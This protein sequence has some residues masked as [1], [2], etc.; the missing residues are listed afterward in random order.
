MV[1][2]LMGGAVSPVT[3][4][5]GVVVLAVIGLVIALVIVPA[6]KDSSASSQGSKPLGC[7]SCPYNNS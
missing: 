7:S 6:V 2:K 3:L 1:K 5:M 4:L